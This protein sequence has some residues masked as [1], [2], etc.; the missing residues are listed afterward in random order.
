MTPEQLTGIIC[1]LRSLTPSPQNG[2]SNFGGHGGFYDG[3]HGGFPGG[4]GG[5]GGGFPQGD[6]G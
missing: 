4:G 1:Y 6:G 5:D 3:G 2:T